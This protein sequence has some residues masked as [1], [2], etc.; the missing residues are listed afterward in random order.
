MEA[1]LN[2]VRSGQRKLEDKLETLNARLDDQHV[3]MKDLQKS[4]NFFSQA[5]ATISKKNSTPF[6]KIEKQQSALDESNAKLAELQKHVDD[7]GRY[8]RG[9]NLRFVGLPE[10]AETRQEDCI[11]KLQQLIHTRLGRN[12]DIENAHRVGTF[13]QG[14]P[15][16]VIAKF[17]RRPERFEVF[18][19]RH[20]FKE[21]EMR[22]YEDLIPKDLEAR[23]KLADVVNEARL[24]GKRT[25]LIRGDLIIEGKKYTPPSS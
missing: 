14:K 6:D 24:K 21:S 22:I 17:L 18:R 19:Q 5:I 25:R 13:Q 9:F 10:E 15:R 12:V 4:A 3:E 8:S 7:A 23:K 16:Q 1:A 2:E 20:A 11:G